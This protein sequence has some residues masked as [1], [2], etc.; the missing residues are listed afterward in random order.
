MKYLKP[1]LLTTGAIL[2]IALLALAWLHILESYASQQINIPKEQFEPTEFLAD[3][4]VGGTNQLSIDKNNKILVGK[5]YHVAYHLN[6]QNVLSITEGFVIE[7]GDDADTETLE[8][9][10]ILT[11]Y[12]QDRMIPEAI[13]EQD[14]A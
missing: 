10:E 12:I 8:A 3:F 7:V 4:D 6:G 5:N 11:K 9:A 14:D 2:F 1:I 13:Q